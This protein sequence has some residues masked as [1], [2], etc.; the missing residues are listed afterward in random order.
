MSLHRP[1]WK[2]ARPEFTNRKYIISGPM[3]EEYVYKDPRPFHTLS[4]QAR[5]K[6]R[7]V[8]RVITDEQ[9]KDTELRSGERAKKSLRRLVNAN[10]KEWKDAE[11]KIQ[12]Q[13]FITFTFAKNEQD[14]DKANRLFT[15]FI[16]RFNYAVFRTKRNNLKYV[17]VHELQERGAIHYHA[18][19]F[20][21]PF[22]RNDRIARI[23]GHGF[24]KT[25]RISS[26]NNVGAYLSKYLTKQG[27][28]A[29]KKGQKRYFSSRYL[30]L[31]LRVRN[32]E[33]ANAVGE[34]LSAQKPIYEA[35]YELHGLNYRSYDLSKDAAAR[36]SVVK[37]AQQP[38]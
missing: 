10:H 18:I 3:V 30:K 7:G 1:N 31:P 12:V 2:L 26:I 32:Q 36:E 28:T 14:L 6:G 11:G 4:S 5:S 19:F 34:L 37:C 16:K 15:D 13:K 24:T 29:R 25:K 23:W 9:R 27:G 38:V 22:V 8:R 21:L 33:R 35:N 20:N 17:A